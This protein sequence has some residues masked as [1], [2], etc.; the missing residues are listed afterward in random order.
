MAATTS[1]TTIVVVLVLIHVIITNSA[2]INSGSISPNFTASHYLFIEN[3]GDF[4]R[5]INRNYTAAI[6]NS[7]PTSPSFYL[8]IYHT[9]SHAVVW[10]ANRNT[11]ISS[12]GQL[13]LSSTGLTINDDNGKPVWSTGPIGSMITALQLLDSGNLV[14]VDQF[15][16][17]VWQSFDFPTDT[18]VPGQKFPVGK[19]LTASVSP[20][21]FFAGEYTFTLT[22]ADGL[23]QWQRLTYY[24]LSMDP[25]SIKDSD[26]PVSYLMVNGSGCNLFSNPGS[27][28]AINVMMTSAVSDYRILKISI[29]GSLVVMRY[30]NNNWV[31]DFTTPADSCRA[32]LR[33]GKLGLCSAG[34]CSCPPGFRNDPNMNSGCSFSDDSL[35]LPESCGPQLGGFVYVPLGAGL[36]YFSVDF[37]N[38][39]RNN[40]GLSSCEAICSSNCS[41][42]ALFYG[43]RSGSCYLIEN[44][45][46]SFISSNNNNNNGDDVKLGFIKA[47]SLTNQDNSSVSDFPV[48][49]LVLLPASG[50]V[51]I[52][53]LAIW[54]SRRTRNCKMKPSS[55]KLVDHPDPY[56]DDLEMFFIAGLPVRFSYEDLV[57]A[58]GDFSTPV[59]SGG[60]GTVYKGVLRD[61]TAVAVKKITAFGSQGH[62]EFGTE[63]AVIGNI[64]HVNLVRLK[65]F[66][67]HG[68]DRFLVYEYMNRGSLDRTLFGPGPP[69]EWQERFEIAVGTARGLAY[70]HSGCEHKIIHCDV[71]PENILLSNDMQV[72][73]SDF[74][75]SKLLSP[76]QSGLFT[77][78]RG[79]RGY[80]APEWLTNEAISDKTD[81]YSYGMVLLELIQGR[82]NC[83]HAQTHG[84]ENPNT[85]P[86]GQS[87]GSSGSENRYHAR[88]F[89]FPLQ[90]LEMHEQGRYLD[91]VDPRLA[92]RV[93]KDE[94]EKLVKVA[95]C[96]VQ[97]EPS[98]RPTMANV[99]A[100]LE[101]TLPV[102][103]PR[104]ESLNF[105]RF[106]GRRFNEPST[107]VTGEEVELP[108]GFMVSTAEKSGTGASGYLFSYMSSTQVSG[109]R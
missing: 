107:A 86:Q 85:G 17:T 12:S 72:K 7:Q 77:T 68:R 23:L 19:F 62:K 20:E 42:L 108:S 105:L 4:L 88:S 74:G 5:S 103:T 9:A 55:K 54:M 90:A 82:K 53:I 75:L 52:L 93:T 3:S 29:F 98:L 56:S 96:C 48:I 25:K 61:K 64:H 37:T 79:T 31:T 80:L 94:A 46:G 14:L 45:L 44:H 91:L 87:S 104:L 24:K 11:P 30:T 43:N 8:L 66:C 51:L 73:I 69:L 100:M 22:S 40:V 36:S 58:T 18:I 95:L 109:P 84:S 39:V 67:T 35:K 50:V 97:E 63:I 101:G 92:G 89:Y 1:T 41:C 33:C 38:P 78:M 6:A 71:K 21:D 13:S 106:Y 81:V 49:G 47:I 28:I 83:G 15:N 16:K 2:T 70:L 27:E 102:G 59:G 10:A 99:V 34:G 26:R 60:F 65:G 76:E 32:P 57:W